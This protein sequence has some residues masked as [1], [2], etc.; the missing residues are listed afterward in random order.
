MMYPVFP[1]QRA[2]PDIG[3]P[4]RP[5]NEKRHPDSDSAPRNSKRQQRRLWREEAFRKARCR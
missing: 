2:H 4:R 1:V 5:A 3:D